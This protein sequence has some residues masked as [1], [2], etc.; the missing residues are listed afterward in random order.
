MD[1]NI[2]TVD[3]C[4]VEYARQAT[5]STTTHDALDEDAIKTLIEI[6]LKQSLHLL[7]MNNVGVRACIRVFSTQVCV[8]K[9]IVLCNID[10]ETPRT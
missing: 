5:R 10:A 1:G 8:D 7:T 6:D 4:A 2:I 3:V 9:W